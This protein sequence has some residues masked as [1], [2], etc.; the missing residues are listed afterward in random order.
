MARI[1]VRARAVDMLGRQQI[2]GI[3]TA[4][5]ELFKNAHDAYA[6]R[7]E[8]DY[9]RASRLFVLRDDG[10]GMT[11]DDFERRW[12]TLG[13]ES[14]VGANRS[15]AP[16]WTGPRGAPRRPILGEKGI[17]RLAIAA[18]GPQVL[19][20]SRAIRQ[21][22]LHD[23]VVALVNWGMFEIAGLDLDRIEVP[24]ETVP[25]GELPTAELVADLVGRVRSNVE[26]LRNDM[27]E[28]HFT[29]LM[30]ELNRL[31][32][33]PYRI[34]SILGAPSLKDDGH[35]TQF[36]I[37]PASDVLDRDIDDDDEGASLTPLKKHLLGF[38]NTMLPDSDLPPIIAE[39]RDRRSDGTVEE[40]VGPNVFLTPE[41]FR[42][43]DHHFEG[44]FDA[45][46][47][48]KG[49]MN[50][51]G[52]A[53]QDFVISWPGCGGANTKC[54]PFAI[55][56]AYIQGKVGESAL[57]PETHARMCYKLDR[58]GGLYIYR[59]GIR[60]LPY[61]NTDYD[62]LNIEARRTKSAGD[63]F[64]S[65]RRMFGSIEISFSENAELVEKAGREGFRQNI[66]YKQFKE[67]LEH[68]FKQLAIIYFRDAAPLAQEWIEAKDANKKEYEILKKREKQKRERQSKLKKE[69]ATFFVDL[70][71][72]EAV[73]T[74]AKLREQ[75]SAT[76]E[77]LHD[78]DDGEVAANQLL[79]LD[80]R[81]QAELNKLRR[82][83]TLTKRGVGLNKPLQRDW[84][85]YQRSFAHLVEKVID[86]ARTELLT[87][88]AAFI[89]ERGITLDNRRRV[90]ASLD[91]TAK[92][93]SGD[94]S[95]ERR[96]AKTQMAALERTVSQVL[97][98]SVRGVTAEIERTMAEANGTEFNQLD[99]E[100]LIRRQ[101]EWE[102]RIAETGRTARERLE[103][104]SEQFDSLARALAEGETLDA[105][106]AA[107]ESQAEALREDLDMYTDLAQVGMALG[108][109]Q[110][111]FEKTVVAIR[112]AIMALKPWADG[113]PDLRDLY[114]TLRT[115]FQNFDG[116]LTLF[117]PL[118]RRL[119]RKPVRLSGEEIRRYLDTVFGLRMERHGVRVIATDAFD[120]H[121][122][123]A[124]PSTF[125]PVF[126]NL[127][128]N[129]IH[130]LTQSDQS[131]KEVRFDAVDE[132]FLVSN[133]G[134]G[135]PTRIGAAIFEYGV[136]TK[137]NGRGIGLFV[138]RQAL[139][140]EGF[141]LSLE[142][143]GESV[144]PVFLI[145]TTAARDGDDDDSETELS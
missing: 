128:D 77:Q 92:R 117:T 113:T 33:D 119:Y 106:T 42:T 105:T 122:V 66:A 57:P 49:T 142:A 4:I 62:F 55:R 120:Q 144:H 81:V 7:V 12:L 78:E 115:N 87:D 132:G 36:I 136:S 121:S 18:I 56:F 131:T 69:L 97:T 80:R 23:L 127:V 95:G 135:I 48:F 109:V 141:D 143:V 21:D 67:I 14:K 89:A 108:I 139:R 44:S 94:V 35:G 118:N 133:N 38:T 116:Y 41:D 64:F 110:H 6:E 28:E 100:A 10:L 50:V 124:F 93:A 70:E 8:V 102:S 29:R 26:A 91:E 74:V 53:S 32:L 90:V 40:L 71:K 83:L 65:Y 61:G 145:T 82:D 114:D 101:N 140:K 88:I 103:A 96:R 31:K 47:Q 125:L 5:H 111:E 9:F 43:A 134:P 27:P 84:D 22:G 130:W 34:D 54:G 1:R 107:M 76:L 25:G 126:V 58:L 60:I 79:E 104:L 16:T 17:G 123:T 98:E 137:L 73:N 13:T 24:I 99:E 37:V 20:L 86:P 112:R 63:W 2:A 72:G 30:G 52:K 46:G 138:S 39:F 3:P 51:F 19:V 129:A 85:A 75:V 45:A 59:E 15:D 68:F 11:R